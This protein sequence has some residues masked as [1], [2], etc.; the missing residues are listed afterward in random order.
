[1]NALTQSKSRTYA[2]RLTA[3]GGGK[4]K[5]ELMEVGKSGERSMD[6][7]EDGAKDASRS[8]AGLNKSAGKL[9]FGAK[10]MGAALAGIA[11][12]GG[13]KM[14]ISSSLEAA[15][16]IG[17]TADKLGVNIE[18]LQELRYAAQLAGVEQRTFDMGLQRFIRR[19]GEAA[20]GTGEAKQA[21]NDMG[22]Q[23]KDNDGRIR[24]AE[25][26]LGDV[27]DALNGTEDSA[28][29]L[30]L[31]FKLFDSEGV[32]LVNVLAGGSEHLEMMRQRAQDLGIVLE[33]DLVR[34]AERAKDELDTLGKVISTNVNR[35][36]LDATPLIVGF[37]EGLS[38][39]VSEAGEKYDILK[40]VFQGDFALEG[41]SPRT[42]KRL[43]DEYTQEF[44]KWG[45]ALE[46]FGPNAS[47]GPVR[48]MQK[49]ME[50][51]GRLAQVWNSRLEDLEQEREE[52]IKTINE[53]STAAAIE[54]D[55][56]KGKRLL[57]IEKQF[58]K[59]LFDL[60][61]KGADK[62]KIEYKQLS[63]EVAGLIFPDG[64]NAEQLNGLIEQAAQI[65]DLRLGEIAEKEAEAA[66]KRVEA[67]NKVIESLQSELDILKLSEKEKFIQQALSRASADATA[68]QATEI[69]KLSAALFEEKGALEAAND[70]EKEA[71]QLREKAVNLT[72]E[73]RS[74]EEVYHD[75]IRELIRLKQEA[76]LSQDT[77]AESSQRSY[78][79]LL[80]ASNTW[81]A[82]VQRAIRDYLREASDVSVE[83]EN[84][85]TSA[86]Q[87]T[88]DAF[89]QWA[90]TGKAS[91]RDLFNTIAEEALRA[92]TS[93]AITQPL[94][95]VFDSVFGAIGDSLAGS[96]STA[97]GGGVIGKDKL[98]SKVVPVSVFANAPKFHGG[99]LVGGE[100]PIIARKGETVF[101]PEQMSALGNV[102]SRPNMSVSVNVQNNA[103]G[104]EAR[105]EARE[106]GNGNMAIEI[107]VDEVESRMARNIGRGSGLA[108]TLESRYGLNPAAGSYR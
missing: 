71:Q 19:V 18:A 81:S 16:T 24:A 20:K 74:A 47:G 94:G 1:M 61:H 105:A 7:I 55:I 8:L 86:L 42:V 104:A 101:T 87:S 56:N 33:E 95:G 23:L 68:E 76:G 43:A 17:K 54:E 12:V 46:K 88:E 2:I 36:I 59:Q 9:R 29:R 30:R 6:K 103:A 89:V 91:A 63:E 106:D 108:P 28:E 22:I 99:G 98:G 82:G 72:L 4:V 84:L 73:L 57:Q 44:E 41:L 39:L 26:L 90:L 25:D 40:Q 15:D 32:A 66:R 107:V 21:L 85:T 67:N 14:L 102:M 51:A 50:E 31:A 65:R 100:V 93:L 64:S 3:V 70:A 92:A 60:T 35:A 48:Y 79:K 97:H 37:S 58:Q 38:Y 34:D 52:N 80:D 10:A 75:E 27:A 53:N 96:F 62:I 83:F 77:F 11:T 13:L 5:A 78:D 49:R 69:R 45:A